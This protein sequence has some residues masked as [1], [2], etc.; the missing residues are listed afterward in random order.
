MAS[1]TIPNGFVGG[2]MLRGVPIAQT[3]P[4]KVFWV[5]NNTTGLLAGQRGGSD[6]NRG[7]F[8]SPFAT[9]G[10]AITQCVANRGDIIFIKPGH[11]ET[12]SSAGAIALNIAGVAVVGL[13]VGS[14]RPTFT[15]TPP[16]PPPSRSPRTTSPS[17]T[18]SSS[19]TSCPSRPVS[20]SPRRRTSRCRRASSAT[21][22]AS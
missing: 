12:V 19:P 5:S 3:H 13:G 6:G 17:R 14:S 7:D 15:L 1:P 18:A 2:V 4:G 22:R 11:A 8:N 10:Y 20:P 9:L 21:R 16:T